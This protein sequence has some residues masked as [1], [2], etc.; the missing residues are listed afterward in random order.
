MSDDF[1]SKLMAMRKV[2]AATSLPKLP[3]T[4]EMQVD[5]ARIIALLNAVN[6]YNWESVYTI[7]PLFGSVE[8]AQQMLN[9][10]VFSGKIQRLSIVIDGQAVL[11]Y[12]M[13]KDIESAIAAVSQDPSQANQD[14]LRELLES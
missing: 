1:I 11:L 13:R 2:H 14:R 12:A 4:E 6:Q 7:A 3:P 9:R 5:R 10:F 8:V